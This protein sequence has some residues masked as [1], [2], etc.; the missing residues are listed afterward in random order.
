MRRDV[1]A[2]LSDSAADFC[3]VVWPTIAPWCG[4]GELVP[5][6]SVSAT[7]FAKTLDILSGID[8]WHVRG[9]GGV[10]GIASRVQYGAPW[11]SFTV[12]FARR[13]GAMTE[14]AKRMRAIEY[15]VEGWLYP[16]LT[17]QA[18]VS[19]RSSGNLLYC[20]MVRTADL[21][22]YLAD[23]QDDAR[24]NRQDGNTFLVAWCSDL[25][26]AGIRVKQYEAPGSAARQKRM[27][28]AG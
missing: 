17:V 27:R 25:I 6:E 18:Y 13:S 1:A 8:A 23:H 12:R 14:F 4:G 2:D 22:R 19:A 7:E 28:L 5:V 15:P 26:A 3:R 16:A 21:F 20:C 24:T 9:D 11:A 10:R